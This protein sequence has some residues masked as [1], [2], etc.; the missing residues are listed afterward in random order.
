MPEHKIETPKS[1]FYRY[2]YKQKDMDESLMRVI[3]QKRE[4]GGIYY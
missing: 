2:E 4:E 1:D 3:K